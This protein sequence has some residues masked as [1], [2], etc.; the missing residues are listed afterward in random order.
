MG[1]L[2]TMVTGCLV[3]IG[4][5]LPPVSTATGAP[6]PAD[7]TRSVAVSAGVSADEY[8]EPP[9]ML[10][11]NASPEPVRRGGTVILRALATDGWDGAAPVRVR[12]YF[13][14]EGSSHFGYK[15][16]A[17]PRCHAQCGSVDRA[18]YSAKKTFLQRRTG[19]WKAMASVRYE[20]E[21]GSHTKIVRA[22]DTVR[23][24]S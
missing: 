6:A 10:F 11:F 12:F 8:P 13:R 9:R 14:P 5:M 22:Y 2:G 23:V 19:T 17:L 16:S 21:D 24:R 20:R 1:P 3:A 7:E 4:V 15:G 18:D